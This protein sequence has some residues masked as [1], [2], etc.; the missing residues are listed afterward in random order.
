MKK[1]IKLLI[2]LSK[3][4]AIPMIILVACSLLFKDYLDGIT[5]IDVIRYFLI[6]ICII[7]V[8]GA[9]L[10]IFVNKKNKTD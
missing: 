9:L 2:K 10:D 5:Y 1:I 7:I 4:L 8:I 3:L 6:F